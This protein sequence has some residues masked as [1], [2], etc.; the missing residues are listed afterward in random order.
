MPHTC[1]SS[2]PASSQNSLKGNSIFQ[3][4]KS[5]SHIPNLI[6][7]QIL[8]EFALKMNRQSDHFLASPLLA[9]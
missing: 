6:S 5:F 4:N 3:V 9:L 7:Q 1:P 2:H 8:S